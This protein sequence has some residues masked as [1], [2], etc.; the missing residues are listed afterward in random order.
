MK[1]NLAL[2]A[3]LAILGT[4]SALAQGAQLYVIHGIPGQSVGIDG[5]PV[6]V[7]VNGGLALQN[8]QYKDIV[9]PLALPAN[10]YTFEVY[11]AGSDPAAVNPVLSLTTSLSD[12]QNVTVIAHLTAANGLALTPFGNDL[13][14]L[15]K[16]FLR[17]SAGNYNLSRVVARHTAAAPVADL[18]V[19]GTPAFTVG[20]G[21]GAS[22]TVY[23]RPYFFALAATGTTTPVLGPVRLALMDDYVYFIYAVGALADGTFDLI[24]Q[25]INLND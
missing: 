21:T 20:N 4:V 14:P 15:P 17:S 6:D 8:F 9:G 23:S 22:A 24:L 11:L 19:N 16:P 13:S 3:V 10:T 25:P 18:L 2:V 5:A 1:K 7:Y 12:G